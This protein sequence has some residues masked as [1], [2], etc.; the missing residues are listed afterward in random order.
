MNFRCRTRW[1]VRSGRNLYRHGPV[2]ANNSGT[3]TMAAVT[4]GHHLDLTIPGMG[5]LVIPF[6]SGEATAAAYVA[7]IT[8][9]MGAGGH[10]STAGST[11]LALTTTALG[12]GVTLTVAA[13]TSADVL[14]ALGLTSLQSSTGTGNVAHADAITGAEYAAVVGAVLTGGA[15]AGVTVLGDSAGAGHPFVQSGTTGPGSTVLVSGGTAQVALGFDTSTH[16]G[17]GD[18][19]ASVC[20]TLATAINAAAAGTTA[21]GGSGTHV[22]CTAPA[23]QLVGFALVTAPGMPRT[24]TLADLTTDPGLALDLAAIFGADAD[25]YGLLLDSNSP[26]EV[27]TPVTG[28]AAWTETNKRVLCTQHG[29][30]ACADPASTTD[31][32]YVLKAGAY[33]R[34][35]PFFQL[36]ITANWLAAGML[37][38]VLPDDPGSDT[39]MFKGLAGVTADGLTTTELAAVF[40]KNGNVYTTVGGTDITQKG[41]SAQGEFA[42]VVVFIDW[43]KAR[44]QERIFAL[45]LNA[46]KLP[47]TDTTGDLFRAEILAQLKAGIRA[48]GLASDPAPTV[49]VPKVKDISV[50]DRRARRWTGITF[51]A[52]LA[53]AVH[54]VG[55]NGT[56]TL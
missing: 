28:A 17:T 6:V 24:L 31:P 25:W 27:S 55:I 42:D 12:S 44:L 26:A 5:T 10:A 49:F 7:T 22:D 20:T 46:R 50:A 40:A 3:A 23:G 16:P 1:A 11:S 48:G 47:F 54:F 8:A 2:L 39:W 41:T 33:T 37:G 19:L 29:D 4:S 53:G 30:S 34:T 52:S 51:A 32:L 9:A 36:S 15:T 56:V 45:Q 38:N 21:V 43:L 14:A 13:S 35:V 18:T